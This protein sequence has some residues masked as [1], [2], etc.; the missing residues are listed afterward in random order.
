MV[1]IAKEQE[2]NVDTKPQNLHGL[3]T[4]QVNERITKGQVNKVDNKTSKSTIQILVSNIFTFFNI[5]SF[6]VVIALVII[7]ATLDS[8]AFLNIMF[9]GVVLLNMIIGIIQELRAKYTIDK[10]RLLSNAKVMV[11]RDKVQQE[12]LP[13]E[14]VLDDILILKNGNQIPTD[15]I[16]LDGEGEVN[17]SLLTGE[18]DAIQKAKDSKLLSGSFVTS[19][20][21]TT[22]VTAVGEDNYANKLSSHA[23]TYVRPKSELLKSLRVIIRGVGSVI[24]VLTVVMLARQFAGGLITD[25]EKADA[26]THTAGAVV[27]MIPAGMVLLTSLALASGAIALS[28]KKTLVQDL[29]C[30]EM[31][32]RVDTLCLDKTGT[33]T[34]GTMKVINID[35]RI[36]EKKLRDIMASMAFALGET[37]QTG[38]ALID[39]FGSKDI[40]KAASTTQFSSARKAVSVTFKDG[41]TYHLG[42]PE[43][44]SQS[45]ETFDIEKHIKAGYRVLLLAE[46][47]NP[48]AVIV[49]SDTIREDAIETIAWF[50]ENGVDIKVISGDNAQTVSHIASRV[51]IEN[52]D[53]FISTHELDENQ[54]R[55]AVNEFT[56]FG[57]VSP[58]QKKILVNEL[59][60]VGKTVAMTG[61]GV[62]D[63]LA[64]RESDCSIAMGNGSDA[65]RNASHLILLE[66]NFSAL[67]SV[68]AQGRR[69]INNVQKSSSLFMFKVMLSIFLSL[70]AVIFL[71]GRYIFEPRNLY[72]LEIFVIG[73]PS[74][75]LALEFNSKPIEGKFINKI[76]KTSAIAAALTV[77]NIA[78]IAL[79][80]HI[81]FFAIGEDEFLTLCILMTTII[82]LMLLVKIAR[83]F[84]LYRLIVLSFVAVAITMMAI[85]LP[86]LIGLEGL[87]LEQSVLLIM[88]S[89]VSFFT[90]DYL[91]NKRKKSPT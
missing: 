42:A 84:N 24:L 39:Y 18:S 87:I 47:D 3:T 44:I 66:N 6:S 77:F 17:E 7:G 23:K 46:E 67:P 82:G 76:L 48:I 33:I 45:G 9:F 29:Y 88:L 28:R 22:Q 2:E 10:L 35:T 55:V 11:I 20:I 4:D 91:L 31:L 71:G 21:L 61:D 59:K 38:K 43:F 51:G 57:R 58:E 30:I 32:A 40:F 8:S 27:G 41:K 64:L 74:F 25:A 72:I 89:L 86:S 70:F 81:D 1:N 73:L 16:V 26:V 12:I 13:E 5:L 62:N 60:T 79:A 80:R 85:F 37:N 68:V 75:F 15:C 53:K 19:G 34:D 36:P 63:I 90:L 50:K 65:A 49:L 52:A 14:I 56:V 54:L 83:P 78:L 69:V